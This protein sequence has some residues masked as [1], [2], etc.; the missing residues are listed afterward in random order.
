MPDRNGL[1]PLGDDTPDLTDLTRIGLW[2]QMGFPELG[3]KED[4][5]QDWVVIV[6]VSIGNSERHY[7][8]DALEDLLEALHE[9][10]P[11][12]LFNHDGYAVQLHVAAPTAADALRW[13]LGRH[14]RTTAQIG[15]T[16]VS[17]LRTE[18]LTLAELE[19]SCQDEIATSLSLHLISETAPV[20]AQVYEATRSILSA[21]TPSQVVD[22]VVNFVLGVGGCVH[23]GQPPE[24]DEVVTVALA[25]GRRSE[26]YAT[27]DTLTVAGFLIEHW[28]P[29]L[30]EDAREALARMAVDRPSPASS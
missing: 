13:A 22:H 30:L 23:L 25:I 4:R 5:V 11:S 17:F 16:N 15:L 3:R 8:L 29:H 20:P 6:E 19:R 21:A 26:M 24:E 18:I 10:H 9:W 28:L 27:G 2:Q 1:N 7:D 12:A 14:D